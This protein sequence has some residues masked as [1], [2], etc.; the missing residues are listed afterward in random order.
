LRWHKANIKG[1]SLRPHDNAIN[2]FKERAEKSQNSSASAAYLGSHDKS[3]SQAHFLDGENGAQ[4]YCSR[5]CKEH[6][7]RTIGGTFGLNGREVKS[8][9]LLFTPSSEGKARQ[10]RAGWLADDGVCVCGA[11]MKFPPF[12]LIFI[13]SQRQQQQQQQERSS[14]SF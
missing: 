13:H 2:N 10:E 3:T 11:Y 8:I 14:T 1:V 12:P 5:N 4:I 6:K 7:Q 9:L